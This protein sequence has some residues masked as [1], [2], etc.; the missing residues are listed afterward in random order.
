MMKF[1]YRYVAKGRLSRTRDKNP[2]LVPDLPI[3]V[4]NPRCVRPLQR[5]G[6]ARL[7]NGISTQGKAISRR[8]VETTL[9]VVQAN[10]EN[11]RRVPGTAYCTRSGEVSAALSMY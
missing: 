10:V 2:R 8:S 9:Q 5:A 1:D 7:I 4:R 11:N 6:K 3:I